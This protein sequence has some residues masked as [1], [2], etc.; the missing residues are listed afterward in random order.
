MDE[1]AEIELVKNLDIVWT[2]T[3]YPSLAKCGIAIVDLINT[4]Y[5]TMTVFNACNSIT[6]WLMKC[7]VTMFCAQNA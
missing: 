1:S 6:N 5:L 3:Y 4:D 7:N 2:R